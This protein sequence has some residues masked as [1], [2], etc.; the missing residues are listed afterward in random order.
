M[1]E[2]VAL[3]TRPPRLAAITCALH[4]DFF[5]LV[6]ENAPACVVHVQNKIRGRPLRLRGASQPKVLVLVVCTEHN[7]M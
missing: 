7:G 6:S 4:W 3:A 2:E 1:T 5:V